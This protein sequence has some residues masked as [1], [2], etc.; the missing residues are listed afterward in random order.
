MVWKTSGRQPLLAWE[1]SAVLEVPNGATCPTPKRT[2]EVLPSCK[3]SLIVLK[4][5]HFTHNTF[6]DKAFLASSTCP[7]IQSLRF[8]NQTTHS[9]RKQEIHVQYSKGMRFH[10]RVM[11]KQLHYTRVQNHGLHW[12]GLSC[13]NIFLSSLCAYTSG[14]LLLDSTTAL[15]TSYAAESAASLLFPLTA[16][17]FTAFLSC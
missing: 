4:I 3:T 14:T 8:Q 5:R 6:S 15:S 1:E 12:K 16:C 2:Y 17:Y 11:R 13:C 10:V 7:P 9:P